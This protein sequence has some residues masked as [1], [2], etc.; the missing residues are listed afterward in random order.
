MLVANSDPSEI[1]AAT[2]GGYRAVV[3]M[4]YL[5]Q[6]HQCAY[7]FTD[8]DTYITFGY[9]PD[10]RGC[11]GE[12]EFKG[13]KTYRWNSQ[14]KFQNNGTNGVSLSK[15]AVNLGDGVEIQTSVVYDN[16]VRTLWGYP[17]GTSNHLHLLRYRGDA[18]TGKVTVTLT[19][20][21]PLRPD[22]QVSGLDYYDGGYEKVRVTGYCSD[23]GTPIYP[24][25]T[26]AGLLRN[27]SYEIMG[28]VAT[29]KKKCLYG[30]SAV[31]GMVNV[32][33]EGGVK[34]VVIEY[35]IGPRCGG[36]LRALY[37]SPI[38][39]RSVPPPPPINEDGLS[40]VKEAENDT[41]T[42]CEAMRYTFRI[43]NVNCEGKYV[44][45]R[46][47]LPA[48]MQWAVNGIGLDTV[49]ALH[50]SYIRFN[51]F[52]GRQ[53]LHIDSLFV[54]GTSTLIFSATAD[55]DPALPSFAGY[56]RYDNRAYIRY[57]RIINDV[58]VP[59]MHASLNRS[60]L[61]AM[62]PFYALW[63]QRKDLVTVHVTKNQDYY[64]ENDTVRY[65][66]CFNNP[67]EAVPDMFLY[68]DFN[69]TFSLA[70]P[71]YF[72]T[73]ITSAV[74]PVR[75]PTEEPSSLYIGGD[76]NGT[77]GFTLPHGESHFTLS[78]VSP[79]LASL[80]YELDEDG[81]QII[82]PN[83]RPMRE[84]LG[85]F[86]TAESTTDDPC[87]IASLLDL[88]GGD[89]TPYLELTLNDDTVYTAVDAPN[90][91]DVA[92]NDILPSRCRP[93]SYNVLP[94]PHLSG[95]QWSL[96][97][98]TLTYISPQVSGIDSVLYAIDCNG[99]KDTARVY[100]NVYDIWMRAY[101]CGDEKHN[102]GTYPNPVSVLYGDT[103]EYKVSAQN[104]TLADGDV[105]ISDTL[106]P[107]LSYVS[108]TTPAGFQ[109]GYCDKCNPPRDILSWTL[110]LAAGASQ[111]VAYTATPVCGSVAS[112]PF[113]V[114]H[115][116]I[117]AIWHGS[118]I[119]TN[120][121]FHQ[122]AGAA[123]VSFCVTLGGSIYNAESQVIDY[124]TTPHNGVIIVPEEGYE[125]VGWSPPAYTS[126]RGENIPAATGIM[127]YDTLH[128]QGNVE[129]TA[130]FEPA[131]LN[132]VPNLVK[133]EDYPD[134]AETVWAHGNE[135]FVKPDDLPCVLRI[136]SADGILQKQ[137]I[138]LTKGVASFPLKRGIYIVT[139]NFGVGKKIFIK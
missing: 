78:V 139:L 28:N 30:A 93:P 61:R 52:E 11:P 24:R 64:E 47:T 106:P 88:S 77:K 57:S 21:T 113:F 135:L 27:A 7:T 38:N 22:F 63:T 82:L 134:C 13:K 109:Y 58:D 112:Q 83:G 66:V 123:T 5:H 133:D 69:E 25:I 80:G 85:L 1:D 102:N 53:I 138:I 55:F 4:T 132:K 33:F 43:E 114:N 2:L 9:K 56:R 67:N 124:R 37:I 86:F 3:P 50:N 68:F 23:G 36:Y 81:E 59:Q 39:L 130:V 34:K 6:E 127:N 116:C 32:A 15:S 60:D 45:L 73:D 111:E 115:A 19:F 105:N 70:S 92:E 107:Y 101:F 90:I 10:E 14:Y 96:N 104:I 18:N 76:A 99:Q 121:T 103:I 26:P 79:A 72:T 62:T 131:N 118:S 48:G 89:Y 75:V 42:T 98:S 94:T 71:P 84:M 120:R 129:L 8:E 17:Y 49:N 20:N 108:T 117:S 110:T 41:I 126:L 128:I 95:A 91:I 46:D 74:A 87:V 31:D 136:Y 97:G 51:D 12:T 35:T 16:G 29:C 100:I 65:D 44:T 125:F 40:F 122:G 119:R 54:P 137:H